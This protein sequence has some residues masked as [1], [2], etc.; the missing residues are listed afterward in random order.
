MH[1]C[2]QVYIK[3]RVDVCSHICF[4][5]CISV[6]VCKISIGVQMNIN[7]KLY[8]FLSQYKHSLNHLLKA[9]VR[10]G[11]TRDRENTTDDQFAYIHDPNGQ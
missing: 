9:S 11:M 2:L 1:E 7:R 8:D 5:L 6:S 3:I 10:V 4:P